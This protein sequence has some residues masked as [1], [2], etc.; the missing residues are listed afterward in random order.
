MKTAMA[1]TG[2]HEAQYAETDWTYYKLNT[3]LPAGAAPGAGIT[4]NMIC[5]NTTGITPPS[6]AGLSDI[7]QFRVMRDHDNAK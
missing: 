7:V 2:T 4:K 3:M 6:G 5:G 1:G